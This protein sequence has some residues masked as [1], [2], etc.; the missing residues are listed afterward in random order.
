[1]KQTLKLTGTALQQALEL[2][3]GVDQDRAA[4]EALQEQTTAIGEAGN[5]RTQRELAALKEALG[6][7]PDACCHL[8][9]DFYEEHGDVY[10]RTGC[11]RPGGLGEFLGRMMGADDTPAGGGLH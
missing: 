5:R 2:K 3:R 7:E 11:E 4:L 8:E 1:M 9:S 6:L 10:V